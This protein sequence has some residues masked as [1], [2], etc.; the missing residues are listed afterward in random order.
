MAVIAFALSL[1]LFFTPFVATQEA[2]TVQDDWVFP[3]LPDSSTVLNAD[4]SY[5]LKWTLNLHNWFSAFC[6][7]CDPT[8]VDFWI[9]SLD[10]RELHKIACKSKWELLKS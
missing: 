9:T 10:K 5:T 6:S 8:Q 2:Q 1:L 4:Q 7:E 3:Q